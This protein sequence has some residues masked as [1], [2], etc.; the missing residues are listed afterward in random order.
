MTERTGELRLRQLRLDDEAAFT[1]AH[2]TMADEFTFGLIYELGQSWPAYVRAN[3]DYQIGRSLEPWM[4]PAT[5]LVA[6]VKGEI[7]GRTS[8]RHK[9]NAA[10]NKEGGHIGYCVL[11]PFRRRGYATEILRQSLIIARAVGVDRALVTCND[12]NIGSIKVIE[13]QGGRLENVLDGT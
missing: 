10:L 6:D 2:R 12:D 11:P 3:K 4:V 7:V 13:S 5:F 8:I 1:E 9:L